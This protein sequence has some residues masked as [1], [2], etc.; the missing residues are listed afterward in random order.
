MTMVKK[1]LILRSYEQFSAHLVSLGYRKP[2][3]AEYKQAVKQ[4][5]KAENLRT[6]QVELNG[7]LKK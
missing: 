3:K 1:P 4:W 5:L 7:V 2:T 6:K